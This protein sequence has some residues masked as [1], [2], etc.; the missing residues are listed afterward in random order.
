MTYE[1]FWRLHDKVGHQTDA[2]ISKYCK[3]CH[4][5]GRAGGNYKPPLYQMEQEYQQVFDWC[6]RYITLQ[7]EH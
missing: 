6:L 7:G 4:K 5:G 2:F 1:S 3:Y